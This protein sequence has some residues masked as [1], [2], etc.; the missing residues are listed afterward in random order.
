MIWLLLAAKDSTSAISSP[1][2]I[3]TILATLVGGSG[4]AGWLTVRNQNKSLA[5]EA[6][7]NAVDAV[8]KA[9]ERVEKELD[10]SRREIER[11][12]SELNVARDKAANE[13]GQLQ[14]RISQLQERVHYLEKVV[15]RYRR[16]AEDRGEEEPDY[17]DQEHH[18]HPQ[19]SGE[20]NE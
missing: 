10:Y 17:L 20:Y 11:L 8:N 13:R 19:D 18:P 4:V 15:T 5:V 3:F 6:A 16:R 2:F 7:D 1:T 12:T 9:L 14:E